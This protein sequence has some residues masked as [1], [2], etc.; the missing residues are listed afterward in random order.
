MTLNTSKFSPHTS[1]T[2]LPLSPRSLLSSSSSSSC[3]L[4]LSQHLLNPPVLRCA[5]S[6]MNV[7]RVFTKAPHSWLLLLSQ[8]RS[9]DA[10]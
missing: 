2:L 8:N 3:T 5:I 7:L 9:L 10:L 6:V 1:N 4:T